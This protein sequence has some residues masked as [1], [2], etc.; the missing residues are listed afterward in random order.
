LHAAASV[1]CWQ[2]AVSLGGANAGDLEY[3][4]LWSDR[5]PVFLDA[6]QELPAIAVLIRGN[7]AYLLWALNYCSNS[8][9][10]EAAKRCGR[11]Y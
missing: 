8:G 9:L 5:N 2:S 1:R 10:R 11:R 3:C 7:T 4:V 6:R